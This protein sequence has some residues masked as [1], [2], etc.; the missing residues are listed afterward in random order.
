MQIVRDLAGFTMGQS[1]NIRRAM[2]KKNKALMEKYRQLFIFGGT[3]DSGREISGAIAHGVSEEIA[4]KIFND[5]S[6]FA[7]YAFN[8]SHAAAYALVGYYTAYLKYYYPTEFMAAMMNSFRFSLS[9]AAWYISC[10]STMGIKVLSPDVNKSKAR[11]STED[12]P[13]GS[14]AIRIGM[15]VIKN[16]GEGAVETLVSERNSGGEFKDF[17][18]FL[19]RAGK[20]GLNRKMIE[21]LI[22]A[23]ALDFTGINRASMIMAVQT[24]LDKL[25][26]SNT[27]EVV[28]QMSLFDT[29]VNMN[30]KVETSINIPSIA[31]YPMNEKLLYEKDVIGIYLSGHPLMS[32]RK[33]IDEFVNFGMN[34]VKEYK[35][36]E[37]ISLLND[38]KTVIMCGLLQKKSIRVTKAKTQMAVLVFED[39]YGPFECAIFGKTLERFAPILNTNSSYLIVGKRRVRDEDDFSLFVDSI[40]PMPRN[41]EEAK[42][43]YREP[44]VRA[45]IGNKPLFKSVDNSSSAS[46]VNKDAF[47]DFVS[48]DNSDCVYIRFNGD[49]SSDRYNRLINLLAF[50]HGTRPVKIY[51]EKSNVAIDVAP[52]CYIDDSQ[53]VISSLKRICGDNSIYLK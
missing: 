31:D 4:D 1:D 19:R 2:S 36:S 21:S 41:D 39:L 11:F 45:A 28:G 47:M 8:K 43:L 5:V 40:L 13:D 51:L 38:D 17:T 22:Y 53:E 3:D 42:S 32:Y 25:N 16:V 46:N 50:L 48:N 27:N 24:E 6:N 34:D 52:I 26:R 15:S 49:P 44:S 10:C 9:Q 23:S 35:D 30:V 7:G 14:K 20:C 12:L 33:Y 29:G 37:N 18:D